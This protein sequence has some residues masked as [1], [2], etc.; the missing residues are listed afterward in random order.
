MEALSAEEEPAVA[1]A[2]A[3]LRTIVA[4][5]QIASQASILGSLSI[6]MVALAVNQT[7][8]VSL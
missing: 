5:G 2:S 6:L 4:I 8:P 1:R 3:T 7:A